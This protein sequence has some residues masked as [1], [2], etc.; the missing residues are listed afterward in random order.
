MLTSLV[1]VD[2]SNQQNFPTPL[3]LAPPAEGRPLAASLAF[4]P[5]TEPLL[6]EL[7]VK[8]FLL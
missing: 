6:A 8:A 3:S 7:P 4:Q 2:A 1:V 5:L